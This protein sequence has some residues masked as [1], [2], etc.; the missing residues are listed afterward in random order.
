MSAT[1]RIAGWTHDSIVDGPGLRFTVF[2]QGCPIGCIGCHNPQT[3]DPAAGRTVSIDTLA[4]QLDAN[5]L[6]SGLTISG[7]EP[8]VQAEGCATLAA[9]ARKRGLD[10]WAY[11]GYTIEVLLRRLAN[12]PGL[13]EFL[14]NLSVLVAGPY[15]QAKR[16]L[17]LEFR[18]S[19]NQRL[20]D[21]PATLSAGKP[22]DLPSL[23][24]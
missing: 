8:T 2:T 20:I 11:S 22:V 10:V 9:L 21:V 18:G 4:A 6:T 17:G 23:K 15:L 12:E 3:W 14:E 16:A 5:P 19:S 24:R 1:L 7:G 13:E